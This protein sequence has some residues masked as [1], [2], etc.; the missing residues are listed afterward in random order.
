MHQKQ[1]TTHD[2]PGS[3]FVFIGTDKSLLHEHC[4]KSEMGMGVR[5]G[6]AN[7]QRI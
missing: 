7:L 2:C 5:G 4:L 6:V 1:T 3:G